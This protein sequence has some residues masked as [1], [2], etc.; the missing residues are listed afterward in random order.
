MQLVA[1]GKEDIVITGNPQITFFKI[2][3]KRYTNFSMESIEQKFNGSAEFGKT[4]SC[5]LSRSGDLINKIYLI[6]T[7]KF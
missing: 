4:L 6:K 1:Y 5:T 2:V 7:L 3:Y